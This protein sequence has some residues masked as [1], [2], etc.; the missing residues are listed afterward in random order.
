[1]KCEIYDWP[2]TVYIGDVRSEK[3][4][5][6]SPRG[7][8]I[9]IVVDSQQD[10]PGLCQHIILSTDNWYGPVVLSYKTTC[11]VQIWTLNDDYPWLKI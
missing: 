5:V 7:A 8:G 6:R 4:D 3:W 11:S 1:M 2:L 9:F 10:S